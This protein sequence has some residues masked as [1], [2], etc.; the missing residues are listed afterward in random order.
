MSEYDEAWRPLPDVRAWRK[1]LPKGHVRRVGNSY[2]LIP[3]AEVVHSRGDDVTIARD[4]TPRRYVEP[5][6]VM[7]KLVVGMLA[8]LNRIRQI[9]ESL[10]MARVRAWKAQIPGWSH[11]TD[12]DAAAQIGELARKLAAVVAEPAYKQAGKVRTVNLDNTGIGHQAT[13][14][15]LPGQTGRT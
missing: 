13:A 12:E 3:N 15:L 14:V 11:M 2:S 7:D 5:S 4:Y 6:E 10:F 1:D 8:E 9:D